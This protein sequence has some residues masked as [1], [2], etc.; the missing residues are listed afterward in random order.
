[1]EPEMD[2]RQFKT[3]DTTLC[4][5]SE[6]RCEGRTVVS[7][8]R[9]D[10]GRHVFIHSLARLSFIHIH[11]AFIHP[12][13]QFLW[14][15]A[16]GGEGARRGRGERRG[17]LCMCRYILACVDFFGYNYEEI[18]PTSDSRKFLSP[19]SQ[20]TYPPSCL[21]SSVSSTFTLHLSPRALVCGGS[22][23]QQSGKQLNHLKAKELER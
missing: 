3:E 11:S 5:Q 20:R 9:R 7:A 6:S 4:E 19:A 14:S 15:R 23:R 22:H 18:A 1:M 17:I 21:S 16:R 8:D 12:F 10:L 13:I 2:P